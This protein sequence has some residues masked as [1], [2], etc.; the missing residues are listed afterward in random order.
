M[1]PDP[2]YWSIALAAFTAM[3]LFF[4]IQVGMFTWAVQ[5]VHGSTV[6]FV[7]FVVMGAA[8]VAF[9]AYRLRG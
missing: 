2:R 4:V 7:A 3:L 9:F 6:V 1:D 8:A 5:S